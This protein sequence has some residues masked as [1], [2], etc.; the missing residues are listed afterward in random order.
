MITDETFCV[1]FVKATRRPVAIKVDLLYNNAIAEAESI[2][3]IYSKLNA[4]NMAVNG[5]SVQIVN[6]AY[7]ERI[8]QLSSGGI[9]FNNIPVLLQYGSY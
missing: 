2:Y 5:V 6:S 1:Y 9:S 4:A 8:A 7:K 3:K